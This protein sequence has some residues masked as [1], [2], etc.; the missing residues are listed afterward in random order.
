MSSVPGISSRVGVGPIGYTHSIQGSMPPA[1][2]TGQA[3][4]RTQ[5]PERSGTES[6]CRVYPAF[7]GYARLTNSAA[8]PTAN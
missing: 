3:V 6:G 8:E 1:L 5:Q 2:Q 4:R 7:V